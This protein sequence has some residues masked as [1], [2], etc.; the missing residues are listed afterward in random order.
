VDRGSPSLFSPNGDGRYD[1]TK[2]TYYLP[3]TET[4]VYQVRNA[5]GTIIRGPSGLGT[6][7]AGTRTLIWNG[8]TNSRARAANGVYSIELATSHL[9]LRG[10]A[11]AHV[12]VD[13]TAPTMT[14]ITGS[15][16]T[17]YPYPDSFR[18][19]FTTGFRLSERS[20]VTITVRSSS[21]SL[22]RSFAGPRPAGATSMAWNGTNASGVRV[23]AGTYYWTLTAQ[24]PA[25]NRRSSSRYSVIV[26]SR[27]LVTKTALV[28]RRGYPYTSAGSTASCAGT[29]TDASD[30]SPNGVWL[31]NDCYYPV[32]G[33]QIAASTYRFTMPVAISYT[34]LRLDSYG[35]SF[36]APST[37]GAGFTRWATGDYTIREITVSG[38]RLNA[39]RTIGTVAATGL[40]S[41]SRQVETT[42][43]VPN[44]YDSISDYDVDYVRLLVTYKVLA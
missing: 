37:L 17:F 5:A 11:V 30:F 2:L 13:T 8:L 18:D 16:T 3:D 41:G 24:D 20:T 6:L 39:W 43:Y 28:S 38:S 32:T 42:L 10:L 31:A 26:N 25:G 7:G 36:Y 9:A 27:H 1:T 19:V 34:S 15:G 35:N 14:S 40:V 23:A 21:G 12:T 29:S 4:V 44:D 22:I 33:Y